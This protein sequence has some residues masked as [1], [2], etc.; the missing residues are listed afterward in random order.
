MKS[1][2]QILVEME[3]DMAKHNRPA[4]QHNAEPAP[5]PVQV[6][7]SGPLNLG[8]PHANRPLDE[9]QNGEAVNRPQGSSQPVDGE[10][11]PL[12]PNAVVPDEVNAIEKKNETIT[13]MSEAAHLVKFKKDDFGTLFADAGLSEEFIAKAMT[14]FEASVNGRIKKEVARLNSAANGYFTEQVKMLTAKM[15]KE[16]DEKQSKYLDYVVT[17]WVKENKLAIENGMKVQLAEAFLSGMKNL[18]LEHNVEIP[19]NKTNLVEELVGKVSELETKLN[20]SM[21]KNIDL[22]KMLR[23]A[24]RDVEILDFTRGMTVVRADKIKS[25]AESIEFTKPEEFK[26]KLKSLDEN[27][28]VSNKNPKGTEAALITEDNGRVAVEPTAA[29]SY[30]VPEMNQYMK[31]SGILRRK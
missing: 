3:A 12:D 29:P 2:H 19:A 26:A 5:A 7:P 6:A 27:F 1:I 4:D 23:E 21:E 16:N 14:I 9:P 11:V 18:F 28:N 13:P 24:A 20:E 25:L 31:V 15:L 10:K 30:E 22:T 17:E 8:D